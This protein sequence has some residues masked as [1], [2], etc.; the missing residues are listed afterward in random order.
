[1]RRSLATAIVATALVSLPAPASAHGPTCDRAV[2]FTLPGVTWRDV[3]RFE[4][5]H[6][7]SA[8]ER[9]AAGS[10]SV[11]TNLS[12]TS[13]PSGF[14]SIGAGARVDAGPENAA[15]PPGAADTDSDGFVADV[16]VPNLGSMREDL[17]DAGYSTVNPGALAESLE[18]L[19]L[20][21]IG[22]ADDSLEPPLPVGYGRY[23]LLA[24]MDES[25]QVAISATGTDLLEP[26]TDPFEV[27]TDADAIDQ[28]VR[29]ALE[30]YPCASLVIDHGDL[31]RVDKKQ[32]ALG[33]ELPE[34]KRDALLAADALLGRLGD[35]LDLRHDLLIVVAPT[36][37]AH[38]PAVHFGVAV[39]VGRNFPAGSTLT[40]PSTQRPGM[41]TLPDVAPTVLSHLG[42][43]RPASMLGRAWFAAEGRI[44]G[45]LAEAVELDRE[46]SFIDSIRTPVATTFV[47]VQLGLY[48]LT[49]AL[50]QRSERSPDS[51]GTNRALRRGLELV[52]LSLAAFP[53]ATYLAGVVRGHSL[54]GFAYAGLLLAIT[55]GLV[56]VAVLLA[57]QG[58]DRLL[59]VA[60]ATVGVFFA[61]MILGG[62]LQL[63]TVFSYSPI[64]AGRFS[65]IGNIAFAV[66]AAATVLTATLVVHRYGRSRW[67]LGA[68]G[69]L[70][71]LTVVI[72][73]APNYGSDVGGALALVPG[74]T[75]CWLLLA[76]KRPTV[77]VIAI[78]LVGAVAAVAL[79]LAFDLS[80]PEESRT[81]LGRLYED[82][83]NQGSQVFFDIIGR[84]VRTQ[85]RVARSTI[86][87]FIVPAALAFIA[88][89]LFWPRRRWERLSNRY[90]AIAAG[91]VGGSIVAVLGFAVNDSGI[92][93]PAMMFSYLVPVALLA[94]LGPT[95]TS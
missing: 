75:L 35:E 46:T 80:R 82:V 84:K 6:L 62:P 55:G 15:A 95:E 28:T 45:R 53:L 7:L 66:L 40:S 60:A 3:E 20:I 74:L 56:A 50:L 54:G 41:V 17:D 67:T 10:I 47:L 64:V 92:V 19:P 2:I 94:H 31:A 87:T 14:A 48:L 24:A 72:D 22:N 65:G 18:P 89:L 91:L 69:L 4:P 88:W 78:C 90:P 5:P 93:V 38:D 30:L 11:R 13:L 61:D 39:A 43:E 23:V 81:H 73:G 77:K 79:L 1:M 68:V 44:D 51:Q 42:L 83:R 70:F 8:M 49:V 63:N 32:Q 25:G 21:G 52:A 33:E 16:S 36:S 86:W 12:R 76:G 57:R 59:I 9:G 58:L 71:A 27:R 29:R 26:A 85:F 34:H 37:P